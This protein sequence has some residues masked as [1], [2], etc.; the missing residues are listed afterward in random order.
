MPLR[1]CE[2]WGAAQLLSNQGTRTRSLCHPVPA[3]SAL[4]PARWL[5]AP[6]LGRAG[7]DGQRDT[8]RAGST[9]TRH[10]R[11]RTCPARVV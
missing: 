2:P 10:V 5:R 9:G 4:P 1:R 6:L 8:V 11:L 7:Q 3:T